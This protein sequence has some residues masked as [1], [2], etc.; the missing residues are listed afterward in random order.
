MSK[1]LFWTYLSVFW[2]DLSFF[3]GQ[4]SK[5]YFCILGLVFLSNIDSISL[6]G[7]HFFFLRTRGF[8][9]LSNLKG[10][11][12]NN[13]K[14]FS[15]FKT[16]YVINY[17]SAWSP[18]KPCVYL[19]QRELFRP[20]LMYMYE[21]ITTQHKTKSV[22]LKAIISNTTMQIF[23]RFSPIERVLHVEGSII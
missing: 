12:S 9:F 16:T 23:K 5:A 8:W 13:E 17:F 14:T 2:T 1:L 15:N 20:Q 19:G 21:Y 3:C 18:K 10:L 6:W 4:I 22:C 7:Y 11:S